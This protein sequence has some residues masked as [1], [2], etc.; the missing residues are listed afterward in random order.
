[1]G[2]MSMDALNAHTKMGHVPA[3][4]PKV[5]KAIELTSGISSQ[6]TPLSGLEPN[7]VKCP[8]CGR[9]FKT[10]SEMNRHR[11]TTHH[12]TKGHE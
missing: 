8:D 12:E 9:T 3:T 2:F 7:Q 1:M 11:D 10:H 6:E 5:E 4:I